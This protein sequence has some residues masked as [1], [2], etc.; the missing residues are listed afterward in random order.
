MKVYCS[1]AAQ[2]DT[3]QRQRDAFFLWIRNLLL[4]KT[5]VPL[6]PPRSPNHITMISLFRQTALP[7]NVLIHIFEHSLRFGDSV[8][9]IAI[10]I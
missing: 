7:Q 6:D 5:I 8:N 1:A 4:Y 10:I 2:L 3:T 9:V